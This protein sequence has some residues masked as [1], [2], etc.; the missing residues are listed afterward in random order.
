MA[1]VVIFGAGMVTRPIVRYLLDQPGMKVTVATR[2]VSKA[3]K[4]IDGHPQGIAK[5]LDVKNTDTMEAEVKD[6]DVVVS[7]VP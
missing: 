1:N 7:L 2:T 4:M 3:E 5:T 6:A